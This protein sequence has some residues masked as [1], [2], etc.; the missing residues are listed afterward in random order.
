MVQHENI[1]RE[2]LVIKVAENLQDNS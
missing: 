1:M 2:L